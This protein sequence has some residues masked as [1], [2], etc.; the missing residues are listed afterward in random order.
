MQTGPTMA[1][2]Q[3]AAVYLLYWHNLSVA[4]LEREQ[5][6]FHGEATVARVEEGP[7]GPWGVASN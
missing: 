6:D 2:E 4:G 5:G 3:C 7:L 1:L